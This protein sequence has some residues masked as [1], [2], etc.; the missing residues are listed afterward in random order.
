[1]V[2]N[3]EGKPHNY[4]GA[5]QGCWNLYGIILAKEYL[6]YNALELTHRLTVDT[7]AVQHPGYP[8]RRSIQKGN[9]RH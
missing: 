8:N 5:V 6:K 1:M 7:Y 3:I 4:I 9:T 2:D